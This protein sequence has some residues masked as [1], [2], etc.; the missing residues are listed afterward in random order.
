[1]AKKTTAKKNKEN[2]KI[3]ENGL[4]LSEEDMTILGLSEEKRREKPKYLEIPEGV[5]TIKEEAFRK[6]HSLKRVILPKS[7]KRIG[8]NAFYDCSELKEIS[9]PEGVAS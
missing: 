2:V 4:V 6:N 3:L 5:L 8:S 7:L 9:I 1:M